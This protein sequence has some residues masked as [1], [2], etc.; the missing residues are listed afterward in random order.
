MIAAY[1]VQA[2]VVLALIAFFVWGLVFSAWD[3]GLVNAIAVLII[4]CPCA[5]GLA[6]PVAIMVGTG[7]GAKMG[8]LIKNA[9]AV[10]DMGK[11][12]TLLVDKTGTLTVGKLHSHLRK[13]WENGLTTKFFGWRHQVDALSE[14]PLASA[15]VEAAKKKGLELLAVRDFQSLTGMGTAGTIDGHRVSVGNERLFAVERANAPYDETLIN[16]L[17]QTGHTVI[18]VLRDDEI[19]G[20]LGVTDPVK[21]STPEAVA[22]LHRSGIQII[23][24]TGDNSLT[25]AALAQ[26]LGLEG[27]RAGCL[28]D[29][30]FEV[31]KSWQAKGNVVAM[32]GDGINDS[33]ALTQADVG[34]AMGTGTD[35]A[36]ESAAITLVKGNL[37]GIARA[38]VLSVLVMRN[39]KQNL[40]FAFVY[41]VVGIPFAALGWLSPMVA[42]AAMALSSVSVLANALRIRGQKLD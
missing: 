33:P 4:A 35:I 24:V 19:V 7:K 12:D 31:V 3:Q 15:L 16:G 14:H 32:A 37:V 2:V 25:A 21:D 34:I 27:F 38:K 23:M 39:I 40:F 20:V 41:N 1:F 30:K 6:T 18:F 26:S 42:A 10:Q 28:P 22:R 8:I 9:Q 13:A 5:L 36:M 17:R 11:V 29:D